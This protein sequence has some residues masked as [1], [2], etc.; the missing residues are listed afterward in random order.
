MKTVQFY[1]NRLKEKVQFV[2]QDAGCVKMYVCGPTLYDNIHLGNTR[3]LIV[4]DM[5]YRLLRYIYG[6]QNVRYVRNVT[7]V[8]DKINQRAHALGISIQELTQQT[9]A[10]FKEDCRAIGLLED[11]E[12]Y[13]VEPRATHYISQIKEMIETLVAKQFAYVVDDH[14]IYDVTKYSKYGE[15]SHRT[16]ETM[17]GGHRVEVAKYKRHPL[18]FVLW[19]PSDPQEPA[20]HSPCQIKTKGRPGWHIECSAMIWA[21]LGNSIDIHGG[22]QDLLFPHHENECAQSCAC[23]DTP[24]LAHTW[25]HN[26]FVIV[27]GHKMS[28]SLKNDISLKTMLKRI[29]GN[30]IRLVMLSTHYRKPL[31]WSDTRVT[32]ATQLLNKWKTQ[33][34]AIHITPQLDDTMVPE[35][36]ISALCDD[37][38]TA[39]VIQILH[40]TDDP[41]VLYATLK[42]IGICLDTKPTQSDSETQ[43]QTL[44]LKRNEARR[45]RNWAEA[46]Q[47]REQLVQLGAEIKDS[48]LN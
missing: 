48:K 17:I 39:E 35:H 31:S 12:P 3:S 2:P 22:G 4:F 21:L 14:V 34:S 20:W 25:L 46:D 13:F 24:Y 41:N 38:N 29:S 11:C 30:V 1:S 8:D 6:N 26:G 10:S 7:D 5:V 47:L 36:V 27:D 23:F 19:K 33:L 9:Y 43:I 28:K 15:L 37:M 44:M 18:D 32:E 40:R 45:Q 16:L 42:F